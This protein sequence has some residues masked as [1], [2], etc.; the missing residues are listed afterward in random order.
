M[1][2]GDS[3]TLLRIKWVA[4]SITIQTMPTTQRLT[5]K[6]RRIIHNKAI[7]IGLYI[8]QMRGEKEGICEMDLDLKK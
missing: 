6:E 7:L 5:N 8:N 1:I 4:E 2:E 3:D